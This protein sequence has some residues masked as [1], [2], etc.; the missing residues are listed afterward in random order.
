M[1]VNYFSCEDFVA[2][3]GRIPAPLRSLTNQERLRIKSLELDNDLIDTQHRMLIMLCRKLDIAVKAKKS[4]QTLRWVML[5]LK[6]FTE[7]HFLRCV[8]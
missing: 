1:A 2:R 8:N 7:F 3:G 6:K 5:E 4:K